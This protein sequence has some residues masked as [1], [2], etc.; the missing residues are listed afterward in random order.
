M[1]SRRGFLAKATGAMAAAAAAALAD[2]AYVIAQPR[3]QWRMSTAF[4]TQLDWHQ[5]VAERLAK[6][7]EE[8]SGGRLRIEV[9]P[10]GQIMG[11]FD[12]FAAASNGTIEAFMGGS[13]YWTAPGRPLEREPAAEW[14]SI[15]PF[16]M[17]PEKDRHHR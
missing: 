4:S 13:Y 11:P 16:G 10:G 3:I 6:V 9:F 7:V 8:I 17:V 12:C 14:F 5:G 15:V 1:S 2:G